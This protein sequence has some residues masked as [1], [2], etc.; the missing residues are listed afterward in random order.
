MTHS[1][2]PNSTSVSPA[3]TASVLLVED[4]RLNQQIVTGLLANIG[5]VVEIAENGAE[6]VLKVSQ[7]RYDIVFMDIQMPV[8][9]GVTATHEIRK[10]VSSSPRVPIVA[11]TANSTPEDRRVCFDAGM[12]DY[13]TKPIDPDQLYKILHKW[14]PSAGQTKVVDLPQG[15]EAHPIAVPG[16]NIQDGLRRILGNQKLY[17]ELLR[18]FVKTRALVVSEIQ[19]LIESGSWDEAR[20]VA[21]STKGVAGTIGAVDVER[22]AGEIEFAIVKVR[23]LTEIVQLLPALEAHLKALIVEIGKLETSG[24]PTNNDQSV[25]L[26]KIDAVCARLTSLL[27]EGDSAACDEFAQHEALISLALPDFFMAIK[28]AIQSFDFVAALAKLD[29]AVVALRSQK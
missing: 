28:Y 15:D 23:P 16:L 2:S 21:H 26:S 13:M 1:D 3:T 20:N 12:D 27:R 4:V 29:Q 22:C 24:F 14:A 5:A 7:N 8:M 18:S 9:D 11:M 25:D 17:F 10:Q 19:R 6:A